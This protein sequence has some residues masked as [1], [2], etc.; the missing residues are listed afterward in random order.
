MRYAR[1]AAALGAALTFLFPSWSAAAADPRVAQLIAASGSAMGITSLHSV[2]TIRITGAVSAVQ[3][4]GTLTQYA[5]LRDGRFAETTTLAP[6]VQQDGYDGKATWNGDGTGLIWNDGSDSGR[7]SEINQ[8]YIATFGLWR[9]DAGGADVNWLG[10]KSAGGKAYDAL[11][12]KP[13]GSLAPFELW[14]D[15]KTHLPARAVLPNGFVSAVIAFSDYRTAKGLTYARRL[16]IES[17][18][19]NNSDV[20]ILS[21]TLD[22]SGAAEHLRR[23]QTQPTDF[24]MQGG[25]TSTVVPITLVENH[26]NLDVMLNGKGPYH[27]IFDT[28]GSNVVDPAVAKEI[29]AL[30]S[31]SAQGSGVGS[32]TESL[33]FARVSTLQVGDAILKDQL[34]AVAPTRMGFGVSAGRPVDGLIGW[35]VLARFVTSFDYTN[36]R[37]VLAI[38]GT[39]QAPPGG[40]VVPFVFYSTQPQVACSID[41]IP[42]ECT[43]DTGARDTLTFMTPYVTAHPQIVPPVTTAVGV[44]G[45]GFGGPALGKLGRV[46]EIGI[47]GF[48][49]Q[50]LVGDYSTQTQGALATPF[51]AANIGGNLLRRFT[52]TFDY[53]AET[54]TLVPNAAFAEPDSYERSG[55]FLVNRGG[56]IVVIDSRPGTPAAMAGIAKGDLIVAV[57][58]VAT[59][60]S[61]LSDVR[62]SFAKPAGSVITLD[63]AGKDGVTRTVKLT[64][65]DYV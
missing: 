51:I 4:R 2:R 54:M 27:F 19:A 24:S 58:G 8:A 37:V 40:R 53:G 20:E 34:F 35:E 52:V 49:L 57:D 23:P 38:P 9:P 25:K 50:N 39:T 26:V 22:P 44:D 63:V 12:I 65:R 45:F 46:Q 41:G 18:D 60:A 48:R 62:A 21:A 55:L 11:R 14:F 42:A 32:D 31:G 17:S 16:H 64:L 29:G 43:I 47:G 33:S 3:L 28:G 10:P 1:L 6:L 59:S 15:P 30:G 56:K 13:A 36:D 5:D 7:S 61:T